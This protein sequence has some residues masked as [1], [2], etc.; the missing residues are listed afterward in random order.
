VG[1]KATGLR[2]DPVDL[3]SIMHSE[4]V[5]KKH[6]EEAKQAKMLPRGRRRKSEADDG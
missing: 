5:G 2:I 1:N 4:N 3:P 6:L